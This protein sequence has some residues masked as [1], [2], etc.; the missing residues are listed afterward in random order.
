MQNG[1]YGQPQIVNARPAV[2]QFSGNTVM[3]PQPQVRTIYA[4]KTT[5]NKSFLDMH[6]YLKS[7]SLILSMIKVGSP[8]NKSISIFFLGPLLFI[9]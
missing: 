6:H 5:K 9:T 1:F 4:H 7:I 3:K 2:P 8:P